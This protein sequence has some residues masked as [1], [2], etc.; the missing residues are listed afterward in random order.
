MTKLSRER[1]HVFDAYQ[2]MITIKREGSKSSSQSFVM[3][4][5]LLLDHTTVF[6]RYKMHVTNTTQDVD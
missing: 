5:I 1:E 3:N 6:S 4:P 2:L